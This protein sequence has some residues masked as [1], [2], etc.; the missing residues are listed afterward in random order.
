MQFQ[1]SFSRPGK[2]WNLIVSQV[3]LR[4]LVTTEFQSEDNVR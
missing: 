4:W 2:L 1:I 3:A